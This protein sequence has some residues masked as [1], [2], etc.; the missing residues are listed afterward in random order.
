MNQFEDVGFVVVDDEGQYLYYSAGSEE[1]YSEVRSDGTPL[2]FDNEHVIQWAVVGLKREIE[3]N[4]YCR[5]HPE[6]KKYCNEEIL[7]KNIRFT[8]RMKIKKV[9][10]ITT[11]LEDEK[12]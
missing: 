12:E 6:L 10:I 9:K 5:T 2:V 1:S 8:S 11:I 4:E 7:T 3:D